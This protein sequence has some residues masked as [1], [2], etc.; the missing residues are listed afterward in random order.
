M[1]RRRCLIIG[2]HAT[3]RRALVHLLQSEG[4][5]AREVS[6]AAE[7]LRLLPDFRP[8]AVLCDADLGDALADVLRAARAG[9]PGVRAWVTRDRPSDASDAVEL[10]DGFFDRPVNLLELR[11]A[12]EHERG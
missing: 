6:A 8:E 7:A 2:G 4:Y 3:R 10:A 5:E 1:N 9:R 11:K 12:L